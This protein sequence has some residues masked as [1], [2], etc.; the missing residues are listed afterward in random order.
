MTDK[1]KHI[2]EIEKIVDDLD[3]QKFLTFL[4]SFQS[5][6]KAAWAMTRSGLTVQDLALLSNEEIKK[7]GKR[8]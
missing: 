1:L 8:E 5:S 4:T 2:P 3:T 7:R 6:V